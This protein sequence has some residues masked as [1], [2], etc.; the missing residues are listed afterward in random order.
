MP[1]FIGK[2]VL[3]IEDST[4]ILAPMLLGIATFVLPCG[5]TQSMQIYS[6]TTGN[7]LSGAM[8][9]AVFALGTL[10][11]LAL[12]SLASV[13]LSKTLQSGLFFKTAGFIVLFFSIFNFTAALVAIGLI[14]P[15]FNF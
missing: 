1:K 8:T 11:V 2:S 15:I 12:I 14:S 10:P 5:F 4:G 9:M 6:L 7:F 3:K 13:K